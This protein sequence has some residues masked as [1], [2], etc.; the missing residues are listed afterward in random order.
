MGP[1]TRQEMAQ[2]TKL[3]AAT[4]TNLVGEL[5]DMDLVQELSGR[6]RRQLS[7]HGA[8]PLQVNP[9]AFN[10]IGID[11]GKASTRIVAVNFSGDV[12]FHDESSSLLHLQPHEA[13]G[14]SLSDLYLL[15]RVLTIGTF[16]HSPSSIDTQYIHHS[17]LRA[18]VC[19][20]RPARYNSLCDRQMQGLGLGN[21]VRSNSRLAITCRARCG[22]PLTWHEIGEQV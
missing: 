18:I 8:V 7:R 17:L 6:A 12:R 20:K 2:R 9:M 4:A 10:A 15:F 22:L 14:A 3:N 19:I 11:L 13:A 1:L 5:L 21:A 16:S